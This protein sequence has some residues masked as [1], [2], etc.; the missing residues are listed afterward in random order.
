MTCDGL[1]TEI[2]QPSSSIVEIIKIHS[3]GAEESEDG[4][5]VDLK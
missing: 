4:V 3:P 5:V 2:R 1:P